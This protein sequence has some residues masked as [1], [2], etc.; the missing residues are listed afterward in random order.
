METIVITVLLVA[1]IILY[2]RE[3]VK[4][5]NTEK[6]QQRLIIEARAD[7]VKRSRASVEGQ[8]TEQLVPHF[9][10]W[11]H[12]PSDARFI[13]TPID[14]VVFDGMSKGEPEKIIIVEVK[15]GS[16]TPTKLQRQIRDLI[17]EGKIE[18]ELLK[19]K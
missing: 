4:R 18:W 19:I 2:I 16:S 5:K 12:T 11:K 1:F 9:P 15:K 8:V 14:Y 17:K 6:Q 7:A 3:L 10:E 13:G